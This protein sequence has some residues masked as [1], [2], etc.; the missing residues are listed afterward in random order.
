MRGHWSYQLI[1]E[2]QVV[3]HPRRDIPDKAH[4]SVGVH[5]R[6]YSSCRVRDCCTTRL[7][8]LVLC[9]PDKAHTSVGVHRHHYNTHTLL[10]VPSCYLHFM[11]V[12]DQFIHS[13][14]AKP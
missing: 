14:V 2:V 12:V 9:T 8:R 6:H 5:R 4:T 3:P 1:R 11:L 13:G 10:F 7:T